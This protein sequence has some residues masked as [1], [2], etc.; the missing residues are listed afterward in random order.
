M[1][2]ELWKS[3]QDPCEL[4]IHRI[5]VVLAQILRRWS[6]SEADERFLHGV[7]HKN[8]RDRCSTNHAV[9]IDGK[10]RLFGWKRLELSFIWRDTWNNFSLDRSQFGETLGLRALGTISATGQ[11]VL[12]IEC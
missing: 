4:H 12:L 6:C 8:G 11:Q 7:H 3:F 1:F 5:Y 2:D 9:F 10:R